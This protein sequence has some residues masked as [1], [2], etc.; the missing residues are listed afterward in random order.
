MPEIKQ[1]DCVLC[2]TPA[3]FEPHDDGQKRY[4]KCKLCHYY[5]ISERA[6]RYL[7][8]HPERKSDL[9]KEVAEMPHDIQILEITYDSRVEDLK[10]ARV[11][12]SKYC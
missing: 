12:R 2:D 6:V 7:Q 3:Q 8:K 4:Y 9:A 10:L 5:A 11:S 1:S